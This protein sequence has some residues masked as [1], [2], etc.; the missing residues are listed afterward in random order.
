MCT[1]HGLFWAT[2]N[3]LFWG[4]VITPD[5]ITSW[6]W[7]PWS[8]PSSLSLREGLVSCGNGGSGGETGLLCHRSPLS[9]FVCALATWCAARGMRRDGQSQW[10]PVKSRLWLMNT[11]ALPSHWAEFTSSYNHFY[12]FLHVLCIYLL[13]S[14]SFCSSVFLFHLFTSRLG[15]PSYAG[16]DNRYHIYHN[17]LVI[18]NSFGHNNH[19]VKVWYCDSTNLG[20]S[21]S[22][23]SLLSVSLYA[24][25]MH[26]FLILMS[27]LFSSSL[28]SAVFG[29]KR[30]TQS[31][32]TSSTQPTS[33]R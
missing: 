30:T 15:A 9:L 28:Y 11:G 1:V 4:S 18:M 22:S 6:W 16:I 2:Q 13:M 25:V 5:L 8:V 26:I 3:H 20:L 23:F 17:H 21:R 29:I 33:T 10:S 14:L 7:V 12:F 32:G 19:V 27:C 24:S 31:L